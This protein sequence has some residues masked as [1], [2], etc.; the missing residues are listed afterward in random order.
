LRDVLT[1][2]STSGEVRVLLSLRS[3]AA[4]LDKPPSPTEFASL[5]EYRRELIARRERELAGGVGQ[6]IEALK[7]LGVRL[8][9]ESPLRTVVADATA[10][11]I[12]VALSLAGVERA[13]LDRPLELI[14]TA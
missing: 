3:T 10:E 9:G 6:T 12:V 8:I 13:T 4:L 11:Q 5:E 1:A 7:A 14:R 2:A